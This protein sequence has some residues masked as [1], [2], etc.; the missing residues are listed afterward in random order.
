M[1]D[2]FEL[3]RGVVFPKDCDHLGHMNV[4]YYAGHF[5][6][7][8]FHLWNKIGINQAQLRASQV[9]LVV[10][11]IEI[12]YI[13]EMIAGDLLVIDGYFTKVGKKSIEHHQ[14]MFNAESKTLCATQ[15]TVEVFFDLETR[16]STEM[17]AFI[18]ERL[19]QVV[20]TNQ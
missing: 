5:D 18:R 16:K 14:R 20:D 7:A 12:N 19:S 3:H 2:P 6:D 8:G 4:R 15:D 10:A 17:P 1:T 11:K 9:C 13:H